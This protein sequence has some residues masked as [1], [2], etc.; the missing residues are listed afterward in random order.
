MEIC[1]EYVSM[2]LTSP[3][4]ELQYL[5]EYFSDHGRRRQDCRFRP[6]RLCYGSD[7]ELFFHA[8]WEYTMGCAG[9]GDL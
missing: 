9:A 3:L 7:S 4:T 8:L 2:F 5:A 6:L 1:E